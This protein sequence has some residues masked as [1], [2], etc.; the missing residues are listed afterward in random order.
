[1]PRRDT[2]PDYVHHDR[3]VISY[4][5]FI[6]LLFAFFVVMYALS[7]VNEEKYKNLSQALSGAFD[8]AGGRLLPGTGDAS[9]TTLDIRPGEGGDPV[10]GARLAAP[11]DAETHELKKIESVLT[12][13]ILP[14]VEA[15]LLS[16]TSNELWLAIELSS[17]ML[18]APGQ[19]T[20]TPAADELLE[21]LAIVLR[22]FENP[23]HVEGFTDNQA[24]ETAQFPSNWEL[25]A[26]RA[27]AVVRVMAHYG[28]PPERM[29][30]VGYGEYQPAYSNR[31][32]QGRELNRRVVIVISRDERVR[33]SLSA[34]GTEQVSDD[35]ISTMLSTGEQQGEAP[36]VEQVETAT[37]GKLF[38]Q[39]A[40]PET[41]QE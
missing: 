30:A 10:A 34:V 21:R 22:P 5:D 33:R 8:S 32:E 25:S 23:I 26:S 11:D 15:G 7:S 12:E 13:R 4:A 35:V 14:G 20:P 18:F 27:A 9:Q 17:N 41:T 3:W 6:T 19:A 16:I 1:M 31:T 2:P 24:I 40:P 39:I 29:A 28:V 38:R 37:G 36:V